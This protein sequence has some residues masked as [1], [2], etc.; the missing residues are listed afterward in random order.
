[1]YFLSAVVGSSAGLVA[2]SCFSSIMVC[3][4]NFCQVV[5]VLKFGMFLL[6][7]VL[8]LLPLEGGINFHGSYA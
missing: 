4:S 1:M 8:E 2:S 6:P 5:H 7:F 3:F